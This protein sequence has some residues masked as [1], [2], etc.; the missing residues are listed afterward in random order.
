[1]GA[2]KQKGICNFCGRKLHARKWTDQVYC[3]CPGKRVDCIVCGKLARSVSGKVEFCSSECREIH[4]FGN[5]PEKGLG[6]SLIGPIHEYQVTVDLL[7]RGWHV[8]KS[9]TH[10]GPVDLI[11]SKKGIL[12][13]VE[14]T[15]AKRNKVT[16][17]VTFSPHNETK[18]DVLALSFSDGKVEYIPELSK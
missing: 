9:V 18:Y 13:K 5:D 11:A 14:V 3:T 4:Y 12:L 10:T 6:V 17:K 8:Y 2:R 16:G 15:K 7:R 1:M